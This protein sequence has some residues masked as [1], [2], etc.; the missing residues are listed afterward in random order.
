MRR[1]LCKKQYIYFT[2]YRNNLLWSAM[3][4]HIV[5][6]GYGLAY[7]SQAIQ[8]LIHNLLLHK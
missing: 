7:K 5:C 1:N 3:C 2:A 4:C 6:M 8:K